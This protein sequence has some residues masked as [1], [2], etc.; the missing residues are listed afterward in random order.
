MTSIENLKDKLSDLL[1]Q[2]DGDVKLSEQRDIVNDAK[3]LGLDEKQLSKLLQEVDSGINWDYIKKKKQESIA[4]ENALKKAIEDRQ[5]QE[6]NAGD[7]LGFI[8]EQCTK[9]KIFDS[10]EVKVFFE[11]AD[12]LGQGEDKTAAFL[13]DYFAKNN[14]IPLTTPR[15][16]SIRLSLESTSWYK[17]KLPPPPPPPTRPFPG[18]KLIV[19]LTVLG[20]TVFKTGYFLWY[21][22]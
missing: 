12:Q 18:K 22:I 10:G 9:D 3:E 11:T 19:S 2:K 8:I 17:D 13:K 21:N 6:Q 1:I 5:K 7:T 16:T 20:H 14:Y 15:G 4:R